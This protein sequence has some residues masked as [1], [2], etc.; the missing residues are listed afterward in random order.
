MSE[1]EIVEGSELPQ[2]AGVGEADGSAASPAVETPVSGAGEADGSAASPAVETP[3]DPVLLNKLADL[4]A[5]T[6]LSNAINGCTFT[7]KE[8][9]A[10]MIGQEFLRKIHEPLLEEAKQHPDFFRATDPKGYEAFMRA[11]KKRERK[12]EIKEAG[13]EKR[14]AGDEATH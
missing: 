4:R 9:P 13:R 8:I 11:E 12:E 2:E 6:M 5:I 14:E 7:G 10:I 3:V 1:Q